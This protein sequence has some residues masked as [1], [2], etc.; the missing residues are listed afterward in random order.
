[1]LINGHFTLVDL[2]I[3]S[4]I[5]S[6]GRKL[7]YFLQFIVLV[8]T[9][10]KFFAQILAFFQKTFLLLVSGLTNVSFDKFPWIL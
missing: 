1:M 5:G 2:I 9:L 10:A 6:E 8:N 3:R 4:R 7:N